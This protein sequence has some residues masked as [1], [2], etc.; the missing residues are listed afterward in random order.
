MLRLHQLFLPC[1]TQLSS[2]RRIAG[3]R[4]YVASASEDHY[5]LRPLQNQQ[6]NEALGQLKARKLAHLADRVYQAA[7]NDGHFTTAAAVL[8][9]FYPKDDAK[10]HQ[11]LAAAMATG[12]WTKALQVAHFRPQACPSDIASRLC[13]Q[14]ID[15]EAALNSTV[16]LFCRSAHTPESTLAVC[17]KLFDKRSYG[18]CLR[19]AGD[20]EQARHMLIDYAV[21][22][23]PD[24]AARY[25]FEELQPRDPK[26][27]HL[28][29]GLQTLS[30]EPKLIDTPSAVD[31]VASELMRDGVDVV[32]IDTE[33]R[34]YFAPPRPRVF[35]SAATAVGGNASAP[36]AA[37]R[38]AASTPLR[39]ETAILQL[40][41][42][43]S[44]YIFD[45]QIVQRWTHY[46]SLM[47]MVLR[48][49]KIMKLGTVVFFS[50]E[51]YM[52]SL[53]WC[54]CCVERRSTADAIAVLQAGQQHLGAE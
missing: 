12:N 27:Q 54:R 39:Y 35:L 51:T 29:L 21:Q 50:V 17:R 45:L 37:A 13:L 36:A 26:F 5:V 1:S 14:L 53:N 34:P 8:N 18:L 32:G 4:R 25:L 19:V 33:T 42:R 47:E 44:V 10:F 3:H 20:D 30:T 7:V 24:Q 23:G 38:Q 41:T 52:Y 9:A 28:A 6:Y 43:N 2:L 15:D 40:A 48:S 49:E 22:Q 46:Q 31:A 11:L 16:D